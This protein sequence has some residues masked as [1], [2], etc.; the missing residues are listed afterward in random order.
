M[1]KS[2]QLVVFTL[3]EQRF[4]IRLSAVE[5]V[6]RSVEITPIPKVESIILGVVN[7]QGAII[8]VVNIRKRIRLLEKEIGLNDQFIICRTSAHTVAFPADSCEDVV[9]YLERE[10]VE[11]DKILPDLE[12]I[13]GAVKLQDDIVFIYNLDKFLSLEEEK[14]LHEVL[15]EQQIKASSRPGKKL[16]K[17][18]KRQK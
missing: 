10:I 12:H 4:A 5:R 8:P 2:S 9:A 13:E 16:K 14:T 17:R 7:Y 6:V 15:E 11:A 18:G 1:E 3:D